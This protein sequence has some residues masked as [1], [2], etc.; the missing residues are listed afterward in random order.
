MPLTREQKAELLDTYREGVASAPNAF[1]IDS[2]G[3]SVPEITELREK[4]RESGGRYVVV[5]NRIALRAIEGAALDCLRDKFVGPT[6]IA[7]GDDPVTMAKVLT[8]FSETVPSFEF[9]GGVLEG[10]LISAEQ[11]GE[12]ATMPSREELMAKLLYLMQS[13]VTRF[14]RTLAALPRDFV[15]VLEQIRQQKE[16]TSA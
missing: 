16:T 13:P 9:K 7:Y 5:K 11:V 8:E 15:L 6:A 14:V 3:M 2:L 12:L 10:E 1:L 4:V